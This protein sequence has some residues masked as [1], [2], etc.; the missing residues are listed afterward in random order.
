MK[1]TNL[2]IIAFKARIPLFLLV[3]IALLS[4]SVRAQFAEPGDRFSI[5]PFPIVYYAP[6]TNFVFGAG[7]NVTFR[8]KKDSLGAKPSNF[9]AGAA[10]SLNKQL[11]TYLQYKVF[12]DNNNYY[13]FGEAGYYKYSYNFYGVGENEV[14]EELYKVDYPRIKINATKLIFPNLYAGLYYQ[15]EDYNIKELDPEGALANNDVPGAEGSLTSA[16]GPVFVLDSRDTVLYPGKGFYGEL[17]TVFSQDFLGSSYNFNKTVLDLSYYQTVGQNVVLAF[18][19]FNSLVHGEAPFQQQ[20]LFGGNK[21]M[22]GY[23]EGRYIDK[24]MAV[25]QTEARFEV[26]KRLGAVAFVSAGALGNEDQFLRMN[27]AR[28][29]YGAGLRFIINKKDH[30]N[31]RLDYAL[32]KN[33]SGFY[34]TV[35]EAF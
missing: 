31:L 17:S 18:N 11:L 29:S 10:Y 28:W 13:F 35:G 3:S 19:S 12:A 4:G 16:I 34:F 32:G 15:Y 23:Y 21:R 27:E 5:F 26:Y 20:S 2:Q 14:S 8:F 7:G 33:T 30:L 6:E 22:R 1:S 9:T 25:L 24:N